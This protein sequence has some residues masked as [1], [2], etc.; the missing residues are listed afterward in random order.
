[1]SVKARL[2]GCPETS[3]RNYHQSLRN[4]PLAIRVRIVSCNR[5]S[6]SDLFVFLFE[7]EDGG[8]ERIILVLKMDAASSSETFVTKGH[9]I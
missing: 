5:P 4:E 8:S 2:T 7:P 6:S 1:V 9:C 3:V